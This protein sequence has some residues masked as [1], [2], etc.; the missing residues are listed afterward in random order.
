MR[1]NICQCVMNVT[2]NKINYNY[3]QEVL[4]GMAEVNKHKRT[5][6]KYNYYHY[7]RQKGK[8]LS[9]LIMPQILKCERC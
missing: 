9:V 4:E 6:R 3:Y 2:K 7:Q 8:H 1:V 5:R